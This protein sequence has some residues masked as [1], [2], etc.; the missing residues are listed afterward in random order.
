MRSFSTGRI[1]MS[2][3]PE[4]MTRALDRTTEILEDVKERSA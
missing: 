2:D 3:R 1:C 4:E